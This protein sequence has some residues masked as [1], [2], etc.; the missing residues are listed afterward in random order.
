MKQR[1]DLK[2]HTGNELAVRK[3]DQRYLADLLDFALQISVRLG[4]A[5]TAMHVYRAYDTLQDIPV[6]NE[7]E[8]EDLC[9]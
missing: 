6:C 2:G 4:Q 9:H 1:S 8:G 3:I 5:E 7:H